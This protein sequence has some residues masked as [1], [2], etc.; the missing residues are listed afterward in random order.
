MDSA[1]GSVSL[2]MGVLLLI[3]LLFILALNTLVVGYRKLKGGE[4]RREKSLCDA[5]MQLAAHHY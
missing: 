2:E 1:M 4:P 5:P 3:D